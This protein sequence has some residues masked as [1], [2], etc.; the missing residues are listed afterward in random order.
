M[1][2][3]VRAHHAVTH[4][5]TGHGIGLGETVQEDGAIF[6]A[7]HRH[8][9]VVLAIENQ[10]AVDLVGEHHDVAIADG[11]GDVVNV[12][13]AEYAAGGILR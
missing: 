4:T 8:D 5:P 3:Q 12:A 1:G 11:V 13:L 6:E 2:G 7:R 10:A 9:R